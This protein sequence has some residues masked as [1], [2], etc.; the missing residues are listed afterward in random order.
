MLLH[1]VSA[2]F[3]SIKLFFLRIAWLQKKAWRHRITLHVANGIVSLCIFWRAIGGRELCHEPTKHKVNCIDLQ[4]PFFCST[5]NQAVLRYLIQT[6]TKS[7]LTLT[8]WWF[9]R[10]TNLVL[11]VKSK[12]LLAKPI[13][14]VSIVQA[15]A[16]DQGPRNEDKNESFELPPVFVLGVVGL[17]VLWFLLNSRSDCFCENFDC[18]G[19]QWE[20]G[21]F[22]YCFSGL[23]I[24]YLP[25]LC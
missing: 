12:C 15:G 14:S 9:R 1:G 7:F 4:I 25:L 5:F 23:K 8:V 19:F 22:I 6:M 24:C 21:S 11:Y 20:R 18:R 3:W 16:T 17:I 10:S 13:W 2:A